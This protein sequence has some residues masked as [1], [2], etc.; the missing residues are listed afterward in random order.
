MNAIKLIIYTLNSYKISNVC[1]HNSE[2]PLSISYAAHPEER[3]NETR[4]TKWKLHHRQENST[5]IPGA[6][7]P[8][9]AAGGGSAE[10]ARVRSSPRQEGVAAPDARGEKCRTRMRSSSSRFGNR[11]CPVVL[12]N[13]FPEAPR[14]D[15]IFL[16]WLGVCIFSPL[17]SRSPGGRKCRCKIECASLH[18]HPPYTLLDSPFPSRYKR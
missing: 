1:L 8:L 11:M 7:L 17:T 13:R 5:K 15:C 2:I 6:P 4:L 10:P 14:P 18:T 12:G 9:S 3:F 16:V